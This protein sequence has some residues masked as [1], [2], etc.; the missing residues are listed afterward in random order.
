MQECE[1]I[2]TRIATAV[3]G[4]YLVRDGGKHA[5]DFVLSVKSLERVRHFR[6]SM[7]EGT[8]SLVPTVKHKSMDELIGHYKKV[9]LFT[10]ADGKKLVLK[11]ILFGDT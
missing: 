8:F 9:H 3:D 2:F 10:E 4:D 5:L 7:G 1:S 6:V 11:N